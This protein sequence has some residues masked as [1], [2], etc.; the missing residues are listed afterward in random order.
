MK[1]FGFEVDWLIGWA[2]CGICWLFAAVLLY[3][4]VR[5]FLHRRVQIIRKRYV[6]MV[7]TINIVTI[8]YLTFQRPLDIMRYSHILE[9]EIALH[10][11]SALYSICHYTLAYAFLARIWLLRFDILWTVHVSKQNVLKYIN[12]SYKANNWYITNKNQY[13][14]IRYVGR[15][16]SIPCV[17]SII[18]S[19]YVLFFAFKEV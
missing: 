5:F 14:N 1:L 2:C 18:I 10:V 15:I 9:N 6:S 3:Y 17:I 8:V 19:V 16:L 12:S 4:S 13:G 11:A 7:L